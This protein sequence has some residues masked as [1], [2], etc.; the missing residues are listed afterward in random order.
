MFRCGAHACSPYGLVRHGGTA[1]RK[2]NDDATK[3][4]AFTESMQF[5]RRPS[6]A[7]KKRVAGSSVILRSRPFTPT[8]AFTACSEIEVR[9]LVA[10]T[11]LLNSSPMI[12]VAIL[13][14]SAV[15]PAVPASVLTLRGGVSN[16]PKVQ[17]HAMAAG[18]AAK[19]KEPVPA[20]LLSGA[21]SGA[22]VSFAAVLS[23]TVASALGDVSP[24]VSKLV[25]G[26]LFPIALLHILAGGNQ[27]FT[28]NTA[29]CAMAYYEGLIDMDALIRNWVVTYAGNLAGSIAFL[30]AFKMT[31]LLTGS[32]AKMAAGITAGKIKATFMQQVVKGIFANWLVCLGVFMATGES[33]LVG[34]MVG[35]WFPVS[36][37]VMIGFEHS[38]ANLFLLPL[39]LAAGAD[40]TVMDT[41]T[42]NIIPV[43]IG[44]IIAGAVVFGGSYSYLYG[45]LGGHTKD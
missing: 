30:E 33:D 9:D 5:E 20:N 34:K 32:T 44:N 15:R 27:L 41:I 1:S 12:A 36:A 23:I 31:G 21:L 13:A 38:I 39:G 11:C 18:G 16:A 43:T 28:G 7:E 26:G 40:A 17:Y 35:A 25:F 37:F 10:F 42:K 24:G 14:L 45:A 29:A 4:A 6:W 19:T 22:Y 3:R 8:L 2:C